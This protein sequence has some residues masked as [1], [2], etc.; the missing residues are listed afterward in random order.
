MV[1]DVL[2][3]PGYSFVSVLNDIRQR[4]YHIVSLL[5]V[6]ARI[7]RSGHLKTVFLV[8]SDRLQIRNV[9]T[10]EQNYVLAA[11]RSGEGQCVRHQQRTQSAVLIA[12]RNRWS[13]LAGVGWRNR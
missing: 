11:K 7:E 8:I 12:I 13:K 2:G 5:F 1:P 3:T 4:Q 10:T 9:D 6:F